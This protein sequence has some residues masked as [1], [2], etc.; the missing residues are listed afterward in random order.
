MVPASCRRCTYAFSVD[1]CLAKCVTWEIIGR[2]RRVENRESRREARTILE[3]DVHAGNICSRVHLLVQKSTNVG[4][5]VATSDC[6]K[7]VDSTWA[8]PCYVSLVRSSNTSRIAVTF[9][10][11]KH[12]VVEHTRRQ[13]VLTSIHIDGVHEVRWPLLRWRSWAAGFSEHPSSNH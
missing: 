9:C 8:F 5:H 6:I 4:L 10:T 11:S 1:T 12:Y 2:D 7:F 13:G 3:T